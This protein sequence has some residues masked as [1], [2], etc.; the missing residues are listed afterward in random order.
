M[1]ALNSTEKGRCGQRSRPIGQI[2]APTHLQAFT[3]THT[4]THKYGKTK[5]GLSPSFSAERLSVT[6]IRNGQ[7]HTKHREDEKGRDGR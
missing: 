1:P 2:Y 4:H 6:M 5:S 3:H 7:S